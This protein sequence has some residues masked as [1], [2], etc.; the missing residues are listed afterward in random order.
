MVSQDEAFHPEPL[1]PSKE[2]RC[3]DKL[4]VRMH[5]L[6]TQLGRLLNSLCIL[7]IALKNPPA[8]VEDSNVIPESCQASLGFVPSTS[9]RGRKFLFVREALECHSSLTEAQK[10]HSAGQ[11]HTLHHLLPQ[12]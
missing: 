10:L 9:F 11:P 1:S 12:A 8:P 6:A 4:I 7:L 2:C 5:N 3:I